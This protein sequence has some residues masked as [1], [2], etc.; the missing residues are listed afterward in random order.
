MIHGA[1]LE[2]AQGAKSRAAQVFGDL[3]GEV[4]VG[5]MPLEQGRYALKVNLTT[6]P[7]EGVTLP[8]EIEGVPVQ[9]EVVGTIRKRSQK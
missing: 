2:Q 6:P 5:I 9:V 3:V 1:T 8:D 4:A 7:N